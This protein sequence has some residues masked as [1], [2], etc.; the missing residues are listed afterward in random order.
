MATNNTHVL[1]SVFFLCFLCSWT[2]H[3]DV[4]LGNP[5]SGSNETNQEN[6]L[7]DLVKLDTSIN[8]NKIPNDGEKVADFSV[9]NYTCIMAATNNFS[10]ENK[11]GEGGFGPV[12][13]AWDLWQEGQGLQLIDPKIS[14]TLPL[15]KNPPFSFE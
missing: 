1:K 13:K 2:S 9:I 8:I 4:N 3:A 14:T 7:L 10:L 12:Y 5:K 15:P 6:G 11:L